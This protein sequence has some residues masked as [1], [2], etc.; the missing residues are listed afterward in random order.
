MTPQRFRTLIDAYGADP[1]RWPEAERALAQ[2]LLDRADDETRAAWAAQRQLDAA[3]SMLDAEAPDA[4]LTRR[5]IACAPAPTRPPRRAWPPPRWWMAGGEFIGAGIAGLAAGAL[6][7]ALTAQPAGGDNG[8]SL[9]A[10]GVGTVFN[11][12][13]DRMGNHGE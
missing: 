13:A 3:L 8:A 12:D 2:A 7:T 10:D 1:A 6:A 9:E 11:N 5:I 4:A